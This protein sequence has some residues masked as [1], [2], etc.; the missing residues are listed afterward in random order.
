M[1]DIPKL[2]TALAEW[3]SCVTMIL[4]Y[5]K[6]VDPA[7]RRRNLLMLGG[8][9]ALLCVLQV[10]CGMVSN[11]LWLVGMAAAVFVM[12][13]TMHVVLDISWSAS[14]YLCARTFLYAEFTAALEWQLYTF[15]F[16]S[17]LAE[18]LQ[19]MICLI[20]YVLCYAILYQI[21]IHIRSDE[22][23]KSWLRV[24]GR[25]LVLTWLAALLMFGLSNIS[26]ISIETPFS[27]SGVSD[28]FNIRTMIDLAGFVMLEAFHVLK[29][30]ADRQQEISAIRNILNLQYM[31]YRESQENIDLINHKYHDLKHQI[32]VI[33]E[34]S[35]SERRNAYLDEIENG[36]R[37]YEAEY[38][39][40]NSVLDTV[41]T[42]KGDKCF[43]YGITMTV[44]A[45]GTLLSHIAVMD[46]CT[47]FGNALD[48]AIEYEVLVPEKDKRLIHVTV[49]LKFNMVC[50]VVENF[51]EGNLQSAAGE[52][53][54]TTKADK[55]YH[56]YGLKSIRSTV[57]KYDGQM[58]M[59]VQDQWFRLEM[60]L[61]ADNHS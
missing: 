55:R 37:R 35:D 23:E 22:W 12:G 1:Q 10:F 36:I 28:I 20:L 14:V 33:R 31:Q 40:G 61:P 49:S 16:G 53:P 11:F 41:L 4:V 56:G 18:F 58:N 29:N 46:L 60:I 3:L 47:I 17:R 5:R 34:E 27:G 30:E 19:T 9:L 25:Q 42:G 24:S 21:E 8:S 15:Y 32:R 44:V 2:Y 7:K 51:Y 59:N 52:L 26:Y 48:N 38:K 54:E 43:K 50:I 39:T 45:D 57:E 13:A 6:I